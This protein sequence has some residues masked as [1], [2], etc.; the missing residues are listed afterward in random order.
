MGRSCPRAANV[1]ELHAKLPEVG[2]ASDSSRLQFRSNI[3]TRPVRISTQCGCKGGQMADFWL[4]VYRRGARSNPRS[5]RPNR[6]IFRRARRSYPT[7]RRIS[8]ASGA[9]RRPGNAAERAWS[10]LHHSTPNTGANSGPPP[11]AGR[12]CSRTSPKVRTMVED[13][14]RLGRLPPPISQVARPFPSTR[15]PLTS[16]IKTPTRCPNRAE[17]W[18]NR[19]QFGSRRLRSNRVESTC[20]R[21]SPIWGNTRKL[22]NMA[23]PTQIWPNRA[24]FRSNR[25]PSLVV[26]SRVC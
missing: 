12:S 4:Q 11:P 2:Y 5:A 14:S 9:E 26:R 1:D 22:L 23:E 7:V 19:A 24:R 20:G 21:P 16:S 17:S 8:D 6:A 15:P 18:S 25:A 10:R 3:R 13:N